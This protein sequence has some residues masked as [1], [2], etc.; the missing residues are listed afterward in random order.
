MR[1]WL[2]VPLVL[3]AGCPAS[4]EALCEQLAD[5]PMTLRIGTG[6]SAWQAVSE[7]GDLPFERGE[8][9]GLHAFGSLAAD[10]IHPGNPESFQDPTNPTVDFTLRAADGTFR[11]GY[12]GLPRLLEPVDG[13]L[14]FVGDL[15][16]LDKLANE[17]PD[18]DGHPA[19]LEARVTD[20]CAREA[21]ATLQ[22]ILRYE[23]PDEP[24]DSGGSDSDDSDTDGS[25]AL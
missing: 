16:V 20:A 9:G 5:T 25:G 18:V 7:Q 2:A 8:Q 13:G 3:A 23:A 6:R 11:G 15:L 21:V 14:G 19:V 12:L 24:V 1:P 22:A 4:D 10:G 17:W